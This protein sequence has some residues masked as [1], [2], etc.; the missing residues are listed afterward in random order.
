[1]VSE[2]PTGEN[3]CALCRAENSLGNTSE[4]LDEMLV[5]ESSVKKNFKRNLSITS[6]ADQKKL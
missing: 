2:Q 5:G 3:V 1:M 4:F 6:S